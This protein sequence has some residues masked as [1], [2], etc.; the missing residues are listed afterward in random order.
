MAR[1]DPDTWPIP[2]VF[3]FLQEHGDVPVDDMYRTFNMGI[4]MALVC[5]KADVSRVLAKLISI[6]EVGAAPIGEIREGNPAVE[7]AHWDR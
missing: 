6:G 3:T 2:P 5:A 7:Y 4:G 1:I